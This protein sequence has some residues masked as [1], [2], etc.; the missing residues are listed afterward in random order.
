[1]KVFAVLDDFLRANCQNC[2][3][4]PMLLILMLLSWDIRKH[5]HSVLNELYSSYHRWR[6]TILRS[7][8]VEWVMMRLRTLLQDL[9]SGSGFATIYS[10]VKQN[11]ARMSIQNLLLCWS[12]KS[13]CIY[14]GVW[15][16]NLQL[17]WCLMLWT[18]HQY[19]I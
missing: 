19:L 15:E 1:M 11:V 9:I 6:I 17:L 7:G 14:I 16:I 18:Y 13:F 5:L 10:V 12:L 2:T 3:S 8:L 4:V